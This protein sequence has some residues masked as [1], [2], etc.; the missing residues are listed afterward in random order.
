MKFSY[1]KLPQ[2]CVHRNQWMTSK[3]HKANAGGWHK[4]FNPIVPRIQIAWANWFR[5][6]G[7]NGNGFVKRRTT[8]TKWEKSGKSRKWQCQ[9]T[10]W[11]TNNMCRR[12]E[13]TIQFLFT[14][15]FSSLQTSSDIIYSVLSTIQLCTI[16]HNTINVKYLKNMFRITGSEISRCWLQ[17]DW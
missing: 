5:T 1:V 12:K 7:C 3:W 10:M 17:L 9:T 4:T 14:W 2:I 16:L 13:P 11:R 15:N 6:L 8:G